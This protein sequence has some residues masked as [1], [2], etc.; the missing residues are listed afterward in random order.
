MNNFNYYDFAFNSRLM[1]TI[2]PTLLLLIPSLRS[3]HAILPGDQ[4]FTAQLR[5]QITETYGKVS[6]GMVSL[7][8]TAKKIIFTAERPYYCPKNEVCTEVMPAP[9]NEEVVM[10]RSYRD[11]CGATVFE[12]LRDDRALDGDLTRVQVF[13]HS[14]DTCKYFSTVP[15]TEIVLTV[16]ILDRISGREVTRVTHLSA[17]VLSQIQY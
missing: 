10:A 1:K 2:L 6:G 12:G 4:I 14:Q 3:A 7:N 9:L 11:S 15:K 8:L 17:S 16:K 5:P 13:D